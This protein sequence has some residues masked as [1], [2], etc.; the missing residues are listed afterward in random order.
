MVILIVMIILVILF[1]CVI[2]QKKRKKHLTT[3]IEGIWSYYIQFIFLLI[4]RAVVHYQQATNNKYI[5]SIYYYH[6][7]ITPYISY[8]DPVLLTK[9]I[10][11]PY[12]I[13]HNE[14]CTL[15]TTSERLS[16]R[17]LI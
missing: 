16:T 15:I 1:T 10:T 6:Y 3:L 14:V 5:T 17:Q 9:P 2:V 11:D 12:H 4:E 7:S 13:S 8:E